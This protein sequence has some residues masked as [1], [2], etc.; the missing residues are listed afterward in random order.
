M[1]CDAVARRRYRPWP[2]GLFILLT[3]LFVPVL[4]GLALFF[5]Y[6]NCANA[7]FARGFY[8]WFVL[9]GFELLLVLHGIQIVLNPGVRRQLGIY[10]G[11]SVLAYL[12]SGVPLFM[13]ITCA[14]VP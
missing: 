8:S 1:G 12:V 7:S 2:L 3:A 4:W 10:A 5:G 11:F 6:P 9:Y 13:I 14:A